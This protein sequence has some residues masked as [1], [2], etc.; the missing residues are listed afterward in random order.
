MSGESGFHRVLY[1]DDLPSPPEEAKQ[2]VLCTGKVYY[3]LLEAREGQDIEDIH[4]LR[5]E[6]IYPFP[7]DALVEELRKYDHCDIVWCQEEPRNMGAWPFVSSFLEEVAEEAGAKNPRPRYAGRASAASPAT[8]SHKRHVKEQQ[9]LI[10]S[11]LTLGLKPKGRI[12]SRKE[13]AE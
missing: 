6:Q 8:G 13:E 1:C 5:L 12:A 2:V 3:D 10:K 4:F 9:A 11:A 7:E